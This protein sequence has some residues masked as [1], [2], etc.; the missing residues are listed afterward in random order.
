[1]NL[2]N[3]L[4]MEY[5]IFD[6]NNSEEWISYLNRLPEFNQDIYFDPRYYKISQKFG[7]SV[8]EC[9]LYIEGDNFILYPY[10]KRFLKK[11]SFDHQ[12]QNYVDIEGAYGLNGAAS[13]LEYTSKHASFF[14]NF[15]DTF[16]SY[17][18]DSNIIAEFTR[19]NSL[20]R[21]QNYFMHTENVKVNKSVIVDLFC[22][23]PIMDSY[24]H[25][26]RK[27]I[28]KAER[29]NLYC[30][31]A[32]GSEVTTEQLEQF[33]DIYEK[34]M[35]RNQASEFF[36]F[37]RK[38][39][40]DMNREIRDDMLYFFIYKDKTC[41][42]TELV[43]KGRQVAYSYLGGTNPEY[44]ACGA[45]VFLKHNVIKYLK[46]VGLHYF[47]LGGGM[48]MDDE[49]FNYKKK[50]SRNGVMDFFIG[51]KIHN[52]NAY[53]EIIALWGR[54]NSNKIKKYKNILTRYWL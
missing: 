25:S 47:Y 43:L 17:C 31:K 16:A 10:L 18:L 37:D 46:S 40:N 39:Y 53:N 49:I 54:N 3:K 14:N 6:I 15:S 45:N 35:L 23:D 26:V 22:K 30:I 24:E 36:Y 12:Y 42:S 50:F 20:Y 41:V 1:M 38:F 8:A 4:N 11:L 29:N 48:A 51:K 52:K 28:K 7:H 2:T 44:Y 32:K 21:N 9:F 5:K 13:T 27:N 19:F 34:T 33:I